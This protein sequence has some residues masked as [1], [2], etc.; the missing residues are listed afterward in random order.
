MK[1]N[2]IARLA[3]IAPALLLFLTIHQFRTAVNL[4]TTLDEGTLAWAEIT[5]YDRTDRKDVTYVSLDIRVR[6]PD[7]SFFERENLTLPYSIGHR[8]GTDSIQVKVSPGAGQEV[9]FSEIGK[10][11]VSIA[12]SNTA[13]SFIALIIAFVAVFSWNRLLSRRKE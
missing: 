7:G 5:R 10:T 1:T 8:V 13:M 2:P 3:W 6:M 9:V 12:W 4:Q 11:H